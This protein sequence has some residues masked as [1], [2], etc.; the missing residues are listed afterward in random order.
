MWDRMDECIKRYVL[1]CPSC[2]QNKDS[3]QRKV[4][5]LQS[6]EIP[7]APWQVVTMDLVTHMPDNNPRQYN[8]IVVFVDKYTKM[9][10]I[11]PCRD[12]LTSAEFVRMFMDTIVKSHGV[13]KRLICDRDPR[14]TANYMRSVMAQLNTEIA[15]STAY[16]PQTDGQTER[17]NRVIQEMLRHYV[18]DI[19]EI[20]PEILPYAEL[21]LTTV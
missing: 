9:V 15:A 14:F 13:P 6:I 5:L 12:T 16:H 8:T 2:Q 7:D 3:N 21:Q 10:H 20:W 11:V 18:M 17:M 4:G 1:S 19:Y